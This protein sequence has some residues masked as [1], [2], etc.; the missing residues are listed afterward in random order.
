[1]TNIEISNADTLKILYHAFPQDFET[2]TIIAKENSFTIIGTDEI[3]NIAVK[4]QLETS[5][6]TKYSFDSPVTFPVVTKDFDAFL[7][8]STSNYIPGKETIPIKLNFQ[9]DKMEL[10]V[11]SQ[12][13]LSLRKIFSPDTRGI[14]SLPPLPPFENEPS[15]NITNVSL[16]KLCSSVFEEVKDQIILKIDSEKVT[17]SSPSTNQTSFKINGEGHG[18]TSAALIHYSL[19]VVSQVS[20]LSAIKDLKISISEGGLTRFYYKFDDGNLW[21]VVTSSI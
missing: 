16:L 15:C 17:F 21:Y 5:K 19:D 14:E 18:T 20:Q 11:I 7:K 6:L 8:H 13:I 9:D 12:N 2:I 4:L 10:S 1:M 3:R